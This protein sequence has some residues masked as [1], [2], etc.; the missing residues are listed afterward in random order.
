MLILKDLAQFFYASLLFF[1][2]I[3]Y[4]LDITKSNLK[5]KKKALIIDIS[6]RNEEECTLFAFFYNILPKPQAAAEKIGAIFCLYE[7]LALGH[8]SLES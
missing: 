6:N 5:K 4:I 2:K 7:S 3:K 8:I 1:V